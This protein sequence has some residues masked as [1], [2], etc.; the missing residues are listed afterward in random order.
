MNFIYCEMQSDGKKRPV[1]ITL[2]HV[3]Q[4]FQQT[5]RLYG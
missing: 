3:S 1:H 4:L 2:M 5:H